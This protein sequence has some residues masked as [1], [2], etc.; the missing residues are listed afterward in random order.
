MK[1]CSVCSHPDRAT[2]DHELA[3]GSPSLRAIAI[4]SGLSKTSLIRHRPHIPAAHFADRLAFTL[5]R[6]L[7]PFGYAL[8]KV[9]QPAGICPS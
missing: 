3:I 6:E 9:Q 4:R 1:H 8:Q 5:A 2:I 7:R